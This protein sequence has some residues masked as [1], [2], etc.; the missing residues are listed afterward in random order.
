MGINWKLDVV[1]I[2]VDRDESFFT[3]YTDKRQRANDLQ[4]QFSRS[5]IAPLNQ[6]YP[7]LPDKPPLA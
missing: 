4:V 2:L 3:L 7:Q 1:G 6:R 5:P